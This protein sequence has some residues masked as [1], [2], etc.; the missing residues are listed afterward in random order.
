MHFS[1]VFCPF[2]KRLMKTAIF[3]AVV[4]AGCSSGSRNSGSQTTLAGNYALI[5]ADGQALPATVFDDTIN[6]PEGSFRLRA[7][8]TSG[9][10]RLNPDGTYEQQVIHDTFTDDAYDSSPRWTDRGTYRFSGG[11]LQ[12]TSNFIENVRF[13]ATRQNN[14]LRVRT[15]LIGENRPVVYVYQK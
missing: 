1:I 14:E 7:A 3:A 11:T 15:D 9:F 10:L 8:A 13:E 2:H 12:F 5:A 4:I 6:I